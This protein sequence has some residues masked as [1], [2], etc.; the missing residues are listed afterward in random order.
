MQTHDNDVRDLTQAERARRLIENG[1]YPLPFTEPGI[2]YARAWPIRGLARKFSAEEFNAA[3]GLGLLCGDRLSC[4]NALSGDPWTL[5]TVA[6][7]LYGAL[8]CWKAKGG[9]FYFFRSAAATLPG[10]DLP[11]VSDDGKPERIVFSR[12]GS[13]F[14]VW[15]P[16]PCFDEHERVHWANELRTPFTM[17]MLKLPVVDDPRALVVDALRSAGIGGVR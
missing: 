7:A 6:E 4:L 2:C 5:G 16:P 3:P 9:I 1:Y 13:C 14:A 10:I 8:Q 11:S 15:T 17:P 12:P